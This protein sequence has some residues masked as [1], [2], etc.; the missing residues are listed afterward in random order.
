MLSRVGAFLLPFSL[1]FLLP[2][3]CFCCRFLDFIAILGKHKKMENALKVSIYAKNGCI[4]NKNTALSSGV[5][6]GVRGI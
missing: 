5:G 6:G 2:N 1:P 3:G 4:S